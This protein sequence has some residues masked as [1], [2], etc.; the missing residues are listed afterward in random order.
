[1]RLLVPLH[2][3][4][5]T[6]AR[7]G[8]FLDRIRGRR[9]VPLRELAASPGALGLRHDVDDRFQSALEVAR[10]EHERG[11]RATYFVLH[12]AC[13]Y[14]RRS[15]F[16]SALRRLQDDLG[17]EVGLHH[18]AV[19]VWRRGGGD[20]TDVLRRELEWLRAAG[21]DVVGAAA[22][23]VGGAY[24]NNWAF[25]DW[26]EAERGVR[27]ADEID[28]RPIPKT[29]LAALGLEYEAYHLGEDAYFSDTQLD[30]HSRRPHPDHFG[31][32]ELGPDQRAIV[33]LHPCHWYASLPDRYLGLARR[34]LRRI[35]SS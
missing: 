23:G 35:A 27:T 1:M 8:R 4:A 31:F 33:L 14:Q 6:Y 17:H 24:H 15:T 29:R 12:T 19:S 22:H 25:A 2:E 18:D 10:L 34:A 7:Y 13:Y 32:D 26:E 16:A 21:L 28:G 5:F 9:V 3:R 20:P 11:L 30:V